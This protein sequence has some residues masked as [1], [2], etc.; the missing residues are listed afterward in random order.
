MFDT[1]ESTDNPV[2]DEDRAVADLMGAYWTN[3]ARTGDPNGEGLP[4]WP[5]W[6]TDGERQVMRLNARA[7]AEPES[8]RPRFDFLDSLQTEARGR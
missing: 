6:T 2:S 3:F 5:A 8:D 7:A 4:G 1:L